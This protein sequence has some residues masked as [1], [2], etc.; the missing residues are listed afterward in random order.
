MP[1]ILG[2][3]CQQSWCFQDFSF[4]FCNYFGFIIAYSCLSIGGGGITFYL[5]IS[6]SS[7]SLVSGLCWGS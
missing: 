5:V 3:L 2:L 6:S 1:R 7:S 4:C